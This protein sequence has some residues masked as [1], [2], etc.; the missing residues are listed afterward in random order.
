MYR[1]IRQYDENNET[2]SM[3]LPK[4]NKLAFYKMPVLMV[5]YEE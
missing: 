2:K 4:W 3:C 1:E 5:L